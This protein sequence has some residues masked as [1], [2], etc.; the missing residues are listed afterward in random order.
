MW[1][2]DL[3][4]SSPRLLTYAYC[5]FK[6]E[7]YIRANH[8]DQIT[9]SSTKTKKYVSQLMSH[10]ILK[11]KFKLVSGL[12]HRCRWREREDDDD[13]DTLLHEDKDLS[14]SRFVVCVCVCVC[15]CECECVCV[16]VCV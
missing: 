6:R 2:L 3:H 14:T 12:D 10:A 9:S 4:R 16:C 7:G 15:V 5:R 1:F 13:D 8:K 11:R